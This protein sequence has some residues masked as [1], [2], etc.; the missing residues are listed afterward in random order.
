[1][2]V[3]HVV[4][5]QNPYQSKHRRRRPE[6][7]PAS[8]LCP[9]YAVKCACVYDVCSVKNKMENETNLKDCTNNLP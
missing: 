7:T 4:E 8:L 5:K 6:P 3:S 9:P 1:V 2:H